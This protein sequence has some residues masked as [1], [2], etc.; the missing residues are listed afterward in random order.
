MNPYTIIIPIVVVMVI[1][2]FM[3]NSYSSIEIL[4]FM[5]FVIIIAIV[6][7][8]YFFG[9][10]LTASIQNLFTKPQVDVAIV[11]PNSINLDTTQTFHIQGAYDYMNAKAICKAYNGKLA[12][13]QNV[14]DAYDKGA[15]WCDY[16]WSADH[17][18]L[19]PTQYK[20]WK[21]YQEL[22]QKEQCGRPGVNGGYNHNLLQKLGV[23]CFG[24]KP[25]LTGEMPK[26]T[27]PQHVIDK[28]VEYWQSQ[29]PKLTVSPFNYDSWSE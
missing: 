14:T 24:Q 15:E 17:M 19:Y 9:I 21:A 26:N 23:N 12:T 2:I 25:K 7:V 29:L 1:F 11:K 6:G 20:T 28:R 8:E 10:N 22:G 13:I 16:G 27:I 3:M 4:L 18:A 5:F